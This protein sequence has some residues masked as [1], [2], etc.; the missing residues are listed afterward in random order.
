[1][2]DAMESPEIVV[3]EALAWPFVAG[4]CG[5]AAAGV[6]VA[7]FMVSSNR[8]IPSAVLAEREACPAVQEKQAP[9]F[10]NAVWKRGACG[11]VTHILL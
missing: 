2:E 5:V 8:R 10:L 11:L 6:C 3:T 4:G 9:R 7:V 1:M